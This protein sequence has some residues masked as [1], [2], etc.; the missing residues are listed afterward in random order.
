[1]T[2][3]MKVAVSVPNDV[4]ERADQMLLE[5]IAET[6]GP[7]LGGSLASEPA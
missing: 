7:V 6:V 1:M 4:F 3:G 5:R 2:C